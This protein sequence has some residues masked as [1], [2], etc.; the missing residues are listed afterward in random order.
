MINFKNPR[1]V[2]SII[3]QTLLQPT[4]SEDQVQIFCEEAV[5]LGFAAMCIAPVWVKLA[6]KVART[7]EV[8]VCTVAGF[9]LGFETIESKVMTMQAALDTGADEIDYVVNL[10]AVKGRNYGLVEAEMEAMRRGAESALVKVIL[11]TGYLTQ[12][13]KKYLCELAVSTGLD[14]VKTATGFGPSGASVAEVKLLA[15][16]GQGRIK[17]KAAGGIRTIQDL[18]A[19]VEAGAH[20][21]G[22]SSGKEII[23]QIEAITKL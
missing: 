1:E 18:K 17:V 11:E 6:A 22:T 9:P 10:G 2:A 4:A 16:C 19:M 3:D 12:K 20:R 7:S 15:E 14:F 8:R 5:A 23:T 21:I 13:E